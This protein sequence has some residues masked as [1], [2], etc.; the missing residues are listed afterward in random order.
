MGLKEFWTR[1]APAGGALARTVANAYATIRTQYPKQTNRGLLL[2]V[3]HQRRSIVQ[4]L[5]REK[6]EQIDRLHTWA[7]E[8]PGVTLGYLTYQL[9]LIESGNTEQGFSSD[10]RILL[11]R[12]LNEE[13]INV[14]GYMPT[15]GGSASREDVAEVEDSASALFVELG[16][17]QLSALTEHAL[18]EYPRTCCGLLAGRDRRVERVYRGTNIASKP[19]DFLLDTAEQ[20]AAFKD[21]RNSGMRLL[22]IY[23]SRRGSALL[24]RADVTTMAYYPDVIYIIITLSGRS[25]SEIRGFQMTDGK[26]RECVIKVRRDG[27]K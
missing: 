22:A 17:D 6:A 21:I 19:D 10:D 9:S 12:I 4:L 2:Q 23:S 5:S 13:I 1:K 14:L 3:L 24:S 25:V 26:I 8:V 20:V 18:H 11:Q 27:Y 16:R 7:S 15:T